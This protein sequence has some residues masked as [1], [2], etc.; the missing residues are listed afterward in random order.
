MQ[1]PGL[2]GQH[3]QTTKGPRVTGQREIT[4]K[5]GSHLF[6]EAQRLMLSLFYGRG[7]NT[8]QVN[9]GLGDGVWRTKMG[10]GS[11]WSQNTGQQEHERWESV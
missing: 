4:D 5:Y 3:Q 1:G 6:Q 8:G 2:G 7:E 11:L 9:V 10:S